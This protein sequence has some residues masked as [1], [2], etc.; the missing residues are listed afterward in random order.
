VIDH[1]DSSGAATLAAQNSG[2]IVPFRPREA[3]SWDA[4]I[5]EEAVAREY[6]VSTRTVRRWRRSG[7][8]S[9]KFEG[10]R[11]YRLSECESWHE[12]RR[13]P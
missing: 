6:K 1:L 2:T 10:V 11:R 13:S 5:T 9:R 4:W 3:R 12:Q 7:M 8:P